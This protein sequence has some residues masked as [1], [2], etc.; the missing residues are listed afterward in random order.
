MSH[1]Q[2]ITIKLYAAAAQDV[3]GCG[4]DGQRGGGKMAAIADCPTGGG[5]GSRRGAGTALADWS[6]NWL[7]SLWQAARAGSH[8]GGTSVLPWLPPSSLPPLSASGM[9]HTHK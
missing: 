7:T 9:T 2:F 4:W 6:L 3:D 1:Y 8:Q 5:R